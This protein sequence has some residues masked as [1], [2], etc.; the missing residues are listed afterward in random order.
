MPI[1]K[2]LKPGDRWEFDQA[3]TDDFEWML[4][5]SIPEYGAMRRTTFEAAR[6]YVRPNTTVFDLGCSRGRGLEPFVLHTTGRNYGA[7]RF[8]ALDKSPQM[9]EA[10]RA[11]FRGDGRVQCCVSD[12]LTDPILA[13]ASSTASL[14]LSVLTL[15]FLPIEHR[16]RVLQDAA[17]TLMPGGA[18]VLVEKVLGETPAWDAELVARYWDHKEEHGYSREEIDA[19]A[20]SLEGVLV[21]IKASWNEELLRSVGLRPHRVWQALN[22]CGWVAVK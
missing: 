8:Y 16:Q 12:L 6:R 1:E 20:K 13:N 3:V 10:C 2:D 5:R 17:D 7:M 22:F 19:K 4:A 9:V 18:L 11:R 14:V 15:Q 21:P